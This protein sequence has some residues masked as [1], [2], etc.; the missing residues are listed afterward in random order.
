MMSAGAR[1]LRFCQRSGF[2]VPRDEMMVEWTGLRVWAP[3]WEPKHPSL[4][5]PPPRGERIKMDATGE[6]GDIHLEPGQI[7]PDSL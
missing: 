6:P 4:D 1:E 5:Q 2:K 3:Y 7:T